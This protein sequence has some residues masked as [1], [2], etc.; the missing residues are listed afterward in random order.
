MLFSQHRVS[1]HK[2][3]RPRAPCGALPNYDY[4]RASTPD[5]KQ[6]GLG[7][8]VYFFTTTGCC[9]GLPRSDTGSGG[10]EPASGF[11]I[12]NFQTSCYM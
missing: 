3:V 2:I 10:V 8:R 1:L 9:I 7:P 6:T 11:A 12:Q 5:Q 4:G